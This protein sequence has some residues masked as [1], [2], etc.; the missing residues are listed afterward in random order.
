MIINMYAIEKQVRE[1][2][3]KSAL[4]LVKKCIEDLK[5]ATPKDTGYAASRWSFSEEGGK[6]VIY[7]DA[8][9]IGLLNNGRSIQ[10][11]AGFVEQILLD[12]GFEPHGVMVKRN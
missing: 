2:A 4:S 7:N 11:P 8:A 10:A 1:Q 12:N 5:R 9:Y 6:F 3:L